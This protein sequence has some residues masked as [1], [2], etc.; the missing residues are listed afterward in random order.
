[1]NNMKSIEGVPYVERSYY[2]FLEKKKIRLLL[3]TFS[4][5][6]AQNAYE[7]KKKTNRNDNARINRK[8]STNYWTGIFVCA[9]NNRRKMY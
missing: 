8:R 5:S 2:G 4:T 1:M 7:R 3:L 6:L 9:E